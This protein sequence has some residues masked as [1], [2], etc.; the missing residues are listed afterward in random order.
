MLKR[1]PQAL[2]LTTGGIISPH[3]NNYQR[4]PL[5]KLQKPFLGKISQ[6][7]KLTHSLSLHTAQPLTNTLTIPDSELLS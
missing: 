7:Q 1:Y 3:C 2:Q 5:K 4:G 6:R